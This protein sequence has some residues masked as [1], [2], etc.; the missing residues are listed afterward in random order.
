MIKEWN[1]LRVVACLSIVLLHSTTQTA[2]VVG[3][4]QIEHY[5]LYRVFLTYATPAFIVLSVII[6]ANR[7]A[8]GLPEGFWS[9]RIKWILAPFLF[10]AVIDAL[11]SN[12]LNPNVMVDLKIF[13]NIFTGNFVGWFII[14]IFQFYLL[15]YIITKFKI[16]LIWLFPVSIGVMIWYSTIIKNPPEFMDG[17]THML[18]LPF[19]AWF[20]YFT[21][22]FIIG[23]HYKI[24]AEKLYKH[25]W[26]TLVYLAISLY[27]V[28]LSYESGIIVVNSRRLD[29]F[30]LVLSVCAV[31]LAWG[32]VIPKFN[33]I[34]V[35]SNYSFGIYLLH[36]Q[37]QRFAAPYLANYF[38]HTSTRVL[39]LF[40]VSLLLSLAIIKLFSM[41]SIGEFIIGKV[42]KTKS[43][44]VVDARELRTSA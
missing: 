14:V 41:V 6:L 10:F 23:K 22:A 30:P 35:I 1:L 11:V 36:W 8:N 40:A 12:Y 24:I 3:Y 16:S 15:H 33:I 17:Y 7:Y 20:G 9:G 27:I 18:K 43:L 2:R 29:L 19:L 25:R 39:A 4:P 42:K 32:Q 31:V 34:T 28:Y 44:K 37:I 5:N 13:D 21:A 26:L 38:Q